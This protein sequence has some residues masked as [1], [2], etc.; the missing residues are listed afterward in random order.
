MS[1][2]DYEFQTLDFSDFLEEWADFFIENKKIMIKL[3]KDIGKQPMVYN[4]N[5][6]EIFEKMK[7]QNIKIAIIFNQKVIKTQLKDLI[8]SNGY[9]CD[10]VLNIELFHDK[11]IFITT[12]INFPEFDR[13]LVKY[14]TETLSKDV[15]IMGSASK[16]IKKN[17]KI[18]WIP[19]THLKRNNDCLEKYNYIDWNMCS[20]KKVLPPIKYVINSI[21]K[22]D[23]SLNKELLKDYPIEDICKLI[24][25]TKHGAYRY[26]PESL[27]KNETVMRYA[28]EN[29]RI[30]WNEKSDII[31][32]LTTEFLMTLS[33]ECIN[34]DWMPLELFNETLFYNG[35]RIGIPPRYIPKKYRT[36]KIYK[37]F[38][39]VYPKERW[40]TLINDDPKIFKYMIS[41]VGTDEYKNLWLMAIIEEPNYFKQMPYPIIDEKICDVVARN[42]G[43]LLSYIPSIFKSRELC[44]KAIISGAEYDDVPFEY[45]NSHLDTKQIILDVISR[46]PSEINCVRKRPDNLNMCLERNR[47]CLDYIKNSYKSLL[48][49]VLRFDPYMYKNLGNIAITI[50]NKNTQK[51]KKKKEKFRDIKIKFSSYYII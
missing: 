9:S 27:Q 22:D 2:T 4:M 24:Y 34:M 41:S 31:K 43:Y 39:E 15:L 40:N 7:P 50:D 36:E 17:D 6:F 10:R 1:E 47:K 45:V 48:S 29:N 32:H 21:D 14:I 42:S 13:A 8:Q 35:I 18:K 20:G 19:V 49:I 37:R 44:L 38:I 28:I 30:Y 26:L 5:G 46:T 12:L 11:G 25:E 3:D 51:N 16:K 23:G 33:P